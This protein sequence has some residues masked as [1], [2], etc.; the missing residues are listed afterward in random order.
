MAS[1]GPVHAPARD[2]TLWRKST[3]VQRAETTIASIRELALTPH[4]R[5]ALASFGVLVYVKPTAVRLQCD[6][7]KKRVC[8]LKG[9]DVEISDRHGRTKFCTDAHQ[10]M[11]KRQKG[12]WE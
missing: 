4:G 1:I 2:E 3:M 11:A 6:V 9:C 12:W 5:K 7:T 10:Q 8:T